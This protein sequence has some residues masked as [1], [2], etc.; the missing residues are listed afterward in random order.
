[1]ADEEKLEQRLAVEGIDCLEDSSCLEG[2]ERAVQAKVGKETGR[3]RHKS[4]NVYH[5]PVLSTGKSG[6][7]HEF[8][9]EKTYCDGPSQP[10]SAPFSEHTRVRQVQ[11]RPQ[12]LDQRSHSLSIGFGFGIYDDACVR[13]S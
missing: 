8:S 11:Q 5:R 9:D 4:H 12:R 7:S 10:S 13:R 2:M 1:M 6:R 3:G